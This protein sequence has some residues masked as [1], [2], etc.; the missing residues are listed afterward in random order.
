MGGADAVL[1]RGGDE[2][3]ARVELST[4]MRGKHDRGR[5]IAPVGSIRE[6]SSSGQPAG[7]LS[8]RYCGRALTTAPDNE[9]DRPEAARDP[10]TPGGR[11]TPG[12]RRK[13][14]GLSVRGD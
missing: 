14:T 13:R 9:R 4:A 6:R 2:Y 10:R 11:S 7:P 8:G 3:G 5:A 1:L 12:W